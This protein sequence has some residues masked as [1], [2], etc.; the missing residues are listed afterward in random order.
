VIPPVL[1]Q[2][3]QGGAVQGAAA[4]GVTPAAQAELAVVGIL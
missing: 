3:M 1:L 4:I 2:T